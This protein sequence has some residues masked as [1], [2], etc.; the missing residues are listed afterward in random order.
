MVLIY[1]PTL[2]YKHTVFLHIYIRV[3]KIVHDT[4]GTKDEYRDGTKDQKDVHE[5]QLDI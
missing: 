5:L 3:Q 1:I 2:Q 4:G